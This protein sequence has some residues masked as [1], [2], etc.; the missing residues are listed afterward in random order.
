MNPADPKIAIGWTTAPQREVAESIGRA[1]VDQK[2][3]ACAQVTGPV[4]S[5]YRWQSKLCQEEE[6]RLILKFSAN[7]Q[8]AVRDA[9]LALHPYD[10]PQWIVTL[11]DSS[12]TDYAAWVGGG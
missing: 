5:I 12:S 9:L 8:E 10:T 11:A 2:L 3:V 7:R 6:F 4:T 1:L